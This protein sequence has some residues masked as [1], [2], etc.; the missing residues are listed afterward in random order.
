[1]YLNFFSLQAYQDLL[2]S[3]GIKDYRV[4][5]PTPLSKSS[6]I[7]RIYLRIIWAFILASLS[8]PGWILWS[9]IFIV[10]K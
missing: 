10:V 8:F 5:R 1:M 7:F 9:P 4:S 2:D 3:H 6:L